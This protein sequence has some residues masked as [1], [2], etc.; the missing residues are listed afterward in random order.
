MVGPLPAAEGRRQCE[1]ILADSRGRLLVEA[2]GRA[3][4]AFAD[5][6][7]GRIKDARGQIAASRS[8]YKDLGQRLGYGATSILEG[9]IELLAGDAEA[10]ERVLREGFELLESIGETGYLSTIAASLAQAI[11]RQKR[12]EEAERFSELSEQAAAP[13]DLAAQVGWRSTRATVLARRGEAE[14][15]EDLAREAVDIA[16]RTDHLNMH[17]EALLALADVFAIGGRPAQAIPAIEEARVL[18]DG[19][20]NLFMAEQARTLLAELREA[21]ASEP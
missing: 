13:G 16:R 3:G 4:I 18:Y 15:A 7:Q 19:K 5:V 20:G 9:E 11:Y 2:A 10:A 12:Y 6:W 1:Q 8:I 14:Q 21:I 17:A